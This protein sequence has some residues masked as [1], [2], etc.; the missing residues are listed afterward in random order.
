[1]MR[2]A[3]AAVAIILVAAAVVIWWRSSG[4]EAPA[5]RAQ[6]VAPS[7]P[8]T[9]GM[10]VAKDVPVFLNGIGTVQAYNMVTVKTRVDGQIVKVD[11]KEGQEV[12]EGS[13]HDW[14][15]LLRGS[16]GRSHSCGDCG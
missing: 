12:K 13:G 9:A 10:V 5:A 7:I 15:S 3:I 2:R 8:V 14:L 4:S 16:C 11:F 1:M 6:T